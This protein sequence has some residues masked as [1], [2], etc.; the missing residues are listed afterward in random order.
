MHWVAALDGQRDMFYGT[1]EMI[2]TKYTKVHSA[3]IGIDYLA[4]AVKLILLPWE[5]T[6]KSDY[7]L[8]Y[9]RA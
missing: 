2:S 7:E 4:C 3:F 9:K 8:L 5:Q 1:L 6:R